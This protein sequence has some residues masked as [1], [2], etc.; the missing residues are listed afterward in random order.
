MVVAVLC[1]VAQF[2]TGLFVMGNTNRV[3][4]F[5]TLSLGFLGFLLAIFQM[6]IKG[7]LV[8]VGLV[9]FFGTMVASGL[10]SHP[11]YLAVFGQTTECEVLRVH[12]VDTSRTNSEF[13]YSLRCG[14]RHHDDVK[15]DTY[16]HPLGE[17][18]DRIPVVFDRHELVSPAWPDQ[19]GVGKA[20]LL[21]LALVVALGFVA[22]AATRPLEPEPPRRGSAG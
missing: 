20:W 1:L 15:L 14:D 3:V 16:K 21:P 8:L 4:G 10:A 11:L 6:R 19:V 17:A 18:G 5:V 7:W 22:F 12:E 13:R 2:A 9:V